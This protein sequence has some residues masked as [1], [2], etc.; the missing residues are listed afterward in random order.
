MI[1]WLKGREQGMTL[2][3][4]AVVIGIVGAVVGVFSAS[5]FSYLRHT[6]SSNA[7]ITASIGIENV[8]QAVSN[9]GQMAQN[10]NLTPGGPAVSSV[11]LTWRD[12]MNGDQHETNYFLSGNQIIRREKL[13][14][15]IQSTRTLASYVTNLAFAQPTGEERLFTMTITST[16]GSPRVSL[17]REYHVTLRAEN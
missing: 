9:D 1:K 7:H 3:E 14:G 16:G 15:A 8:G 5:I 17:T 10:A 11:D 4:L 12:P 2:I 6:E 13:N